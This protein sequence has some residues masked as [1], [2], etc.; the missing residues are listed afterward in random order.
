MSGRRDVSRRD[1]RVPPG[2]APQ[3]HA[4]PARPHG[5]LR[6]WRTRA[7][8]RLPGGL[9]RSTRSG[10]Q[11]AWDCESSWGFDDPTPPLHPPA[12]P[13]GGVEN[14]NL[15]PAP[16]WTGFSGGA[17]PHFRPAVVRDAGAFPTGFGFVSGRAWRYAVI[18]L[19]PISST[20]ERNPSCTE[21]S[22]QRQDNGSV[23]APWHAGRRSRWGGH[24]DLW[25]P[26]RR[27]GSPTQRKAPHDWNGKPFRHIPCP[28]R[29]L[30][31][32]AGSRSNSAG[33][34][35]SGAPVAHP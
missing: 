30:T 6:R 22:R 35:T 21:R 27:P 25:L 17:P 33:T 12:R 26:T 3:P 19:P 14:P 15:Q 2:G 1:P 32:V 23:D 7:S 9:Q 4:A 8:A 31:Y 16:A 28:A 13:S 11:S 10:R 18:R 29:A 20:P 5:S 24:A 34:L